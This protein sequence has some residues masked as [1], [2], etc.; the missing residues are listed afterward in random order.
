MFLTLVVI[1][2]AAIHIQMSMGISQ[3]IVPVLAMAT[4]MIPTAV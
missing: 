2:G 3:V 1:S 4:E